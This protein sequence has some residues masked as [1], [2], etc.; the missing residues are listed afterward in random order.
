[1][2]VPKPLPKAGV[3]TL[4]PRSGGGKVAQTRATTAAI[5]ARNTAEEPNAPTAN[6]SKGDVNHSNP[7]NDQS[8]SGAT[9]QVATYSTIVDMLAAIIQNGKLD[10]P[11][12]Q[13]LLKVIKIAKE[14]EV[15]TEEKDKSDA[16]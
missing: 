4:R 2:D 9:S 11:T 7:T 1:M 8:S 15:R 12:K 13:K 3:I 14:A 10:I 6:L 16:G 5:A